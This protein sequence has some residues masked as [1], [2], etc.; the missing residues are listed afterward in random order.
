MIVKLTHRR[1]DADNGTSKAERRGVQLAKPSDRIQDVQ[2]KAKSIA[3]LS[4]DGACPV[5]VWSSEP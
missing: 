5:S 3:I 2:K 1:Y 4:K